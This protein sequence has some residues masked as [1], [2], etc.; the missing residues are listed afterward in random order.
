MKNSR[1]LTVAGFLVVLLT[2]KSLPVLAFSD[3]PDVLYRIMFFGRSPGA[4]ITAM[5]GAGLV[6]GDGA[7]AHFYNPAAPMLIPGMNVGYSQGEPFFSFDDSQFKY[8]GLTLNQQ[9]Y[10]SLGFS[11]R[12]FDSGEYDET[13]SEWESSWYTISYAFR[14]FE[15]LYFGVSLNTLRQ[16]PTFI[17]F[18][19]PHS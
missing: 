13:I 8:L 14:A 16:E 7:F 12:L 4:R 11:G 10:G 15:N 2:L 18:F 17:A 5:G 1:L 9:Q 19:Q 3:P 6:L